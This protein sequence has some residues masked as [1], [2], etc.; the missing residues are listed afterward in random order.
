MTLVLGSLV[1]LSL[2]WFLVAETVCYIAEFDNSSIHHVLV[3]I[4]HVWIRI[5]NFFIAIWSQ[6]CFICHLVKFHWGNLLL[7]LLACWTQVFASTNVS[8]AIFE[9]RFRSHSCTPRSLVAYRGVFRWVIADSHRWKLL[10]LQQ[11]W[12]VLLDRSFTSSVWGAR[13]PTLR[14]P[15]PIHVLRG[16]LRSLNI[17]VQIRPLIQM[18]PFITVFILKAVVLY[19][20]SVL[21]GRDWTTCLPRW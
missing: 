21:H 10:L 18:L 3:V 1:L 20:G 11:L 4:V 5:T 7:L 15:L 13:R 19:W 2:E 16:I 14:S 8:L 17:R 12:W 9:N 6:W